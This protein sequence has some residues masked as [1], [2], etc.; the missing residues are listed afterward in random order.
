MPFRGAPGPPSSCAAGGART[1]PPTLR[2][3]EAKTQPLVYTTVLLG[4][5]VLGW[6]EEVPDAHDAAQE[7]AAD[8]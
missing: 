3:S 4:V 7:T 2:P 1:E 8:D 6:L 5:Q